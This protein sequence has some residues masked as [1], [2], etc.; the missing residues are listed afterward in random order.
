LTPEAIIHKA[1]LARRAATDGL[2]THIPQS[3]ASE[4]IEPLFMISRERR[5][6]IKSVLIRYPALFRAVRS[7]Y[8]RYAAL[9]RELLALIRFAPQLIAS[10][11]SGG[12]SKAWKRELPVQSPSRVEAGAVTPT[13]NPQQ[14][15]A[16]CNARGLAFFEGVN[17][18]Y[19]PPRTWRATPLAPVLPPYPA[20][21]GLKI[22]QRAG[23]ADAGYAGNVSHRSRIL[24][25]NY[26]H[27]HGGAPRLYDLVEIRDGAKIP[28]TAFVIEDSAAIPATDD[29]ILRNYE[30]YLRELAASVT[31][32][33]HFGGRMRVLGGKTGCFLY[34]EIPGLGR[35]AKRSPGV[36]LQAWD[37]LLQRAHVSI[38]GKV[39]FDIGCNLGL[40]GA[41][42]LRRGARWVHGWD[43]PQVVE[44]AR[45]VLLSVGCTRFSLTGQR[46]DQDSDLFSHLP[47]HLQTVDREGAILSYLSVREHLGWLPGLAELPWRYMLYEGHPDDRR[48]ETY[49]AELNAR[50]PVRLLTTDR[51][52]DGVTGIC[53][54]ALIERLP[55]A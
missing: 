27:L 13:L 28:W 8:I 5:D 49:I 18:I 55:R 41:E 48:I 2:Q 14:L 9:R 34:Q 20:D 50:I 19:L 43:Q 31:Q 35:P 11:F 47:E 4:D 26:Q 23:N 16:W 12:D 1:K 45:K 6:R 32:Q 24:S 54:I 39:V 36:R 33:S 46:L 30:S 37:P 3:A 17:A 44:A 21:A 22:A 15:K 42:Y 25:M 53:D 7:S 29:S 10:R 38:E 52:S 40:M 51:V